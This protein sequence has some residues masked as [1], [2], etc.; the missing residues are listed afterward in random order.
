MVASVKCYDDGWD[1]EKVTE[2]EEQSR[3][4]LPRVRL[5]SRSVRTAPSLPTCQQ[6]TVTN[7]VAL[8]INDVWPV[9]CMCV[10]LPALHTHAP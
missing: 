6:Q 5:R 10:C 4:H 9:V 7:S 8:I 3:S 1:E 2:C